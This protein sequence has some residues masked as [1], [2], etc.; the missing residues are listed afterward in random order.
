MM[1]KKII[2]FALGAC[3]FAGTAYAEEGL[4]VTDLLGQWKVWAESGGKD[5]EKKMIDNL[6]EF[7]EG[8]ILHTVSKDPRTSTLDVTVTFEVE[9][10]VIKKQKR[11]GGPVESC[12]VEK[13]GNEMTV[14]CSGLYLFMKKVN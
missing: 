2:V 5:K 12:K 4:K 6:W 1:I 9:N 14:V 10:G 13:E 11:P 3:L 8:N 7:K